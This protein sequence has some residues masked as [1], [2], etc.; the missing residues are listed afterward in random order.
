VYQPLIHVPLVVRGPGFAGGAVA[1]G[2]VQLADVTQ[3]LATVAGAA[4]R[5]APTAAERMTLQQAL[6][7]NGRAAA[8][9]ER[10][11]LSDKRLHREQA[12]AP[13]YDFTPFDCHL[14][15]VIADGWKLIARDPGP[16]ELYH[17]AADPQEQ[18]NL[19]D[20]HPR[21]AEA[22]RQM[23]ADMHGRSAPHPATDGLSLDD[24]EVV[25]R[26]LRDLGY[27]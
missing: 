3:T 14:A 27:L 5:L 13:T 15:A 16:H 9:C 22:L 26:R 6:A 17:L 23:L 4:E 20:Q 11:R 18:H 2:L 21:Q 25:D 8:V 7:G 24:S 19:L 1:P 10:E 12:E